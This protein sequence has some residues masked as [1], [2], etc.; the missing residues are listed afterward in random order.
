MYKL[1]LI[2]ILFQILSCTDQGDPIKYSIK[3][4]TSHNFKLVLFGRSGKNDTIPFKIS[5]S[6]ILSQDGPPFDDGPFGV[7]DSL[8][9]VFDDSKILTY[10][11]LKSNSECID[12]VKNP[13]CPYS[14]YIC[15]DNICTY[16]IDNIEYQKAK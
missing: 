11:P 12:S 6:K 15:T 10:I 16:E 14:N 13:F 8:K 4:S 2:I 9:A 1:L 5:E 7:F 3:N